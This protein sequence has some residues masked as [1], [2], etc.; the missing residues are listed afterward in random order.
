MLHAEGGWP[1]GLDPTDPE[2]TARFRKRVEKEEEYV[3]AVKTMAGTVEHCLKQNN[4]IDIYEEYFAN[5]TVEH[6]TEPPSARNLTVFK[7]PQ[8][9]KRTATKISWNP[10]GGK[11]LAVAYSTL[12][13]QQVTLPPRCTPQHEQTLRKKPPAR[14]SPRGPDPELNANP[15]ASPARRPRA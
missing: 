2:Q 4:A 5:S 7:D 14:A 3:N 15:N 1:D 10:D 9:I 13:F 8:K 11:K 6:S 12:Q